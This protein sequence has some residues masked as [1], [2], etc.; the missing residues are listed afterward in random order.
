MLEPILHSLREVDGVQ[1]TMV[2]DPTAAIIAHNAHT[3]YDLPVLQQVARAVVSAADAVQLIQ[4]DWEVLTSHFGEGKLLL[5]KLR[6][7]GTK[8]RSYVLVVI[9]NGTLN[10]AFL[11]VALRVAAAKLLADLEN[12]PPAPST[13]APAPAPAAHA[14]SVTTSRPAAAEPARTELARTGIS[15]SGLGPSSSVGGS[16]AG[17]SDITVSDAASSAFLS[18]CTRALGRT[19]GPIA[20][21]FVKE[22]VRRICGERPFSRADGPSLLAQLAAGIEDS[23]DR[24]TFQRATRAL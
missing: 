23:E 20:K 11:G 7:P 15:W 4:E 14:Q 6:T 2:V 12:G 22:A 13:A 21:V 3:I 8:P 17:H 5:R 9:A 10:V 1:G 16:T 19:A 24:A 18:G